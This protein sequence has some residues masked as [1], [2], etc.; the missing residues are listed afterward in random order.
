MSNSSVIC[1]DANL[2]IKQVEPHP[3]A[4]VSRLWRTWNKAGVRLHAPTLAIY[5]VV[6]ALYHSVKVGMFSEKHGAWALRMVFDMPITLHG[7]Q[8][9]HR[10]ALQV[11]IRYGLPATYDAHYV[12][13]AQRLA[14]DLW[15]ADA[16]LA[17]AVD[18]RLT[19]VRLVS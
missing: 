16:K 2:I 6:N 3:P 19:S 11:A 1:L 9:L 10:Q 4:E 14:V 17:K 18:D 8:D 12:A 7:D 13:L 15:T 5:E